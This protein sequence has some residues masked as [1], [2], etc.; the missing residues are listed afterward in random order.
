MHQRAVSEPFLRTLAQALGGSVGATGDAAGDADTAS[1]E[2]AAVRRPA[3]RARWACGTRKARPAI[4]GWPVAM[5]CKTP[6]DAAGARFLI[7]LP[8]RAS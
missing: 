6:A 8:N 1:G 4:V 5:D 7:A 2:A 3:A